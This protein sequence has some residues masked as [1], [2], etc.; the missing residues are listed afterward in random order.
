MKYTENYNLC[1]PEND[2]FYNVNQFNE[3]ADT[4]DT[5]LKAHE[6][7]IETLRQEKNA[8]SDIVYKKTVNSG[9]AADSD[10]NITTLAKVRTKH[11][12]CPTSNDIYTIITAFTDGTAEI[13]EKFQYA[14]NVGINITFK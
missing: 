10:P 5:E 14:I 9:V 12:N 6:N 1:K 3:N 11:E 7:A 4:I 8:L 2:D 13:C